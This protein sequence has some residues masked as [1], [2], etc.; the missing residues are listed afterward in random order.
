MNLKELHN[1][2]IKA[3]EPEYGQRE[4]RSI[5]K[6][7]FQYIFNKQPHQLQIDDTAVEDEQAKQLQIVRERLLKHEPLQYI[8]GEAEFYGLNFNLTPS[9]L[10]P[11]PE[12]EELVDW[13]IKDYHTASAA[14]AGNKV[15]RILDI[16]TGSGCIAI[17]LKKHLE[18]AEV[19][20][21]DISNYALEV[22]RENAMKNA[23]DVE[24]RLADIL[25]E[26]HWP[27]LGIFDIIISNPPYIGE[28][29]KVEMPRNVLDYEPDLA[30]FVNPDDPLIFYRKIVLF[31]KSNLKSEGKLF[32]ETHEKYGKEVA[33]L[34]KKNNFKKV[35][36]RNDLSG[37]ARM[38]LSII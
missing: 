24:F 5:S 28:D 23:V 20:A 26:K 21:I 4:A 19:T 8:I 1:Q 16:G 32:F 17:S 37:K 30:L 31:A 35:E 25:D 27:E 7:V 3:L 36:L 10:I 13:V 14:Y 12:T 18:L 9:V 33:E 38:V 15:I 11:R 29:E 22:A 2:F 34:L 6:I